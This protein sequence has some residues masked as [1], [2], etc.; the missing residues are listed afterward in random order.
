[1]T[2]TRNSSSKQ[3]SNA[4]R[5]EANASDG[6]ALPEMA[7]LPATVPLPPAPQDPQS[8]EKD[9]YST[10]AFAE[11]LDR[12]THAAI[13]RATLGL[14]PAAMMSAW[15]DW[16]VHLAMSPGKRLKLVEKATRKSLKFSQHAAQC[17]THREGVAPC[18]APLPQDHRFS[19]DAWNTLP[20]QLYYQSFLLTQQWWHNATTD[21]PGVTRQHERGVSFAARQFLDVFSP[22]NFIA[23]NPTLARQTSAQLGMNL[24]RGF[25]YW[26]AD[27]ERTYSG[28]PPEGA[29]AFRP[30]V[31]VAATPGKVIFRNRLIELIQYEPTTEK[32]RPEPVFIIPAWIMK[33]YILD[34]S[35]DNS[36]VRWLLSEGYTVFMISW[37][38]PGP[39]D[40]DLSFDDYIE[41]GAKAGLQ[42]VQE[43]VPDQKVHTT[44]Y[45][46]GGT[47]LSI[48]AA[49]LA[50]DGENPFASLTLL[51]AQIDFREAGELQLFIDESQ[52]AF[53]ED[54]MWEQGFLD[55]QQM[56]GAFQ[57]L[58]SNDLIWSKLVHD[59][60]MGERAPMSDMMAWNADATRM[61]YKMHS[62]YL[63]H[64]YLHNDLTEGRFEVA[65]RPV[66]VTDISA[67]VFAVG[68]ERDH[69]APWRSVY[70]L[71]L[72]LDTPVTFVLASGGH[73]VGVVAAP[74]H[75][76]MHYRMSTMGEDSRYRE[77]ENWAEQTEAEQ[78]SW[79]PAWTR[80]LAERSGAPVKPPAMAGKAHGSGVR[81]LDAAPGRYV[82]QK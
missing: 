82:F 63:R 58:R 51:A 11:L 36:M 30:G 34:L 60:L 49:A 52:L 45:C 74:D 8:I 5:P 20:F 13:A 81:A 15:S 65:G 21:V 39:E 28:K 73:N 70:K 6:K 31:A 57:L 4:G 48:T 27:A 26:L 23:T 43:V 2:S 80:W 76:K 46:L 77:P 19:D 62:A 37:L 29:E 71:N 35:P 64:L 3:R 24:V 17:A 40:R 44:G 67:P 18:I 56:A 22:S 33:Y 61:P 10:T 69:V 38:N 59:Y 12:S 66:S 50:R 72:F 68:T 42:A 9:S 7:T 1:M 32:V 78:G 25:Q 55:T 54:M 53:L 79:W 16:W 47:L 14:S 75:P 41:L